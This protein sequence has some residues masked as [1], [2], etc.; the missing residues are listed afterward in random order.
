M[1]KRKRKRHPANHFRLIHIFPVLFILSL[2]I[3]A[4]FGIVSADKILAGKE[5][6]SMEE[7]IM[8][9][10]KGAMKRWQNGDPWGWAE[11]SAQEV[12][13][14]DPGITKHIEGL[15]EYKKYLQQFEEKINYQG[16]EFINPKIARHDK[17][18]VLTY[19]YE[20]TKTETDGSIIDQ[21][22][23]NTTEVYCLL[24]GQWKIIHTHWSFTKQK[25]PQHTE[26]PILVEK[27]PKT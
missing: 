12:T 25:L 4:F 2:G 11:I 3:S 27:S 17:M 8:S 9:L 19:N 6:I 24:D 23:W 21:T 22:L 16:S 15:E 13:Y 20:S 1:N 14:I 18:A 10:E 5:A 26:V 7:T